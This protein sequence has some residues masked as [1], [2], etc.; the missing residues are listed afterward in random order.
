MY[1]R[2]LKKYNNKASIVIRECLEQK[3]Q[4]ISKHYKDYNLQSMNLDMI[5][6]HLKQD[7][8]LEHFQKKENSSSIK[9]RRCYNCNIKEYYMNECRKSK[10]SQQVARMK[11]RL[12]Q[13]KQKLATVLTVLFSKNKHNYLS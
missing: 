10:K 1:K 13:Q 2:K 7:K 11:R 9:K 4:H 3:K 12:K 5:Q 8:R 6:R